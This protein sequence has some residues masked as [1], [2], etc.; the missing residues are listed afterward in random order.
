MLMVPGV[1]VGSGS[2]KRA[3]WR[4]GSNSSPTG[5]YDSTPL[6][7]NAYACRINYRISGGTHLFISVSDC[8]E[9]YQPRKRILCEHH[10]TT[11]KAIVIHIQVFDV[12]IK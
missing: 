3:E 7:F 4:L 11:A 8:T 10:H 5:R 12:S 1:L 2:W 9:H 6:I